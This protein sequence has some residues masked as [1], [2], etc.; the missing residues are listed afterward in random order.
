MAEESN[1]II[2]LL[3]SEKK[4]KRF[5]EKTI[6]FVSNEPFVIFFFIE[7]QLIFITVLLHINSV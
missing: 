1:P 7:I 6:R 5:T 4:K 2:F 3:R